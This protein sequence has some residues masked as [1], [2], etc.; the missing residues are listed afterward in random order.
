MS[1]GEEGVSVSE[2]T[3]RY[4]TPS[5]VAQ[6]N[7]EADLWVVVFGNVLD[8]TELVKENKG[9]MG[10]SC[11]LSLLSLSPLSLSSL[12][13]PS[14]SP[15]SLSSLSIRSL[16][17]YLSPPLT[18]SLSSLFCLSLCIRLMNNPGTLVQPM[19]AAAGTDISNWFDDS[20][21][22]VSVL[23]ISL[24]LTHFISL[25]LSF[26]SSLLLLFS[27]NLSLSFSLI[28]SFSLLS[29]YIFVSFLPPACYLYRQRQRFE[30]T[31]CPSGS[32]PSRDAC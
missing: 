7:V 6:H 14:L 8:L 31:I 2:G 11:S 30:G 27:L 17:L 26:S 15:L 3:P 20:T 13:L 25:P 19:I 32:V 18:L 24:I 9:K 12:S 5:E 21:Q 1:A 10:A 29:P 22:D 4:F 16:S 28:L 23:F